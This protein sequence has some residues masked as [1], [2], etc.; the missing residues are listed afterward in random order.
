MRE[1][2]AETAHGAASA[3]VAP[4][5]GLVVAAPHSGAGKTTSTMVLIAA[6]RAR[7]L[8]VQPFKAGPDFLDPTHLTRV[9]GRPARTLDVTLTGEE[10]VVELATRA[11]RDA[12]VGVVEG[13]MG[14]FDGV[15]GR[16]DRGSTAEIAALLGWPV[17]LVVDAS[18]AARSIAAVVR[19]FR[20][21]SSAIRV[22]AVLFA[23]VAGA[24]HLQML[25]DAC[26]G[27]DVAG[28]GG[29]LADPALRIAERHL[30]LHP[31]S[32]LDGPDEAAI[33]RAAA[34]L[35]V[36]ALLDV[37]GTRGGSSHVVRARGESG[38]VLRAD[39]AHARRAAGTG[40]SVESVAGASAATTG[41]SSAPAPRC[42]IGVARDAAFCFYYED[43]L[44]ALRAA[45]A[46][47]VEWSPLRDTGL[48]DGT[49]G[50]YIGGGYP[51]LHARSL[52]VNEGVR[53][54][55][56]DF[57]ARG[58]MVYAECGGF[59]FL[60]RALA[61]VDGDRQPM[62]GL[63]PGVAAMQPRLVALGYRTW[64]WTLDGT[65]LMVRGQEFRHSALVEWPAAPVVDGEPVRVLDDAVADGGA[66][67]ASGVAWRR[68]VAGYTHLHFGATPLLAA[69]LVE[70]AVAA[71]RDLGHGVG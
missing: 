45:G 61:G 30:G 6:L 43:N 20:T 16:S 49:D 9:A 51:E 25:R 2:G 3:A 47:L 35:D 32:A 37:L 14:L 44:D 34:A 55:V 69:L 33:A 50:L 46:E 67:G 28:L 65:S 63:L 11:L 24:G 15:D 19:G 71:R 48:P 22:A 70:R 54:A 36:D 31:A 12:D 17:V 56:R 39:P 27:E 7:G 26:A 62:V 40:G 4:R 64:T 53:H 10:Y 38:D 18:A 29:V 68:V 58:G 13:M 42:R 8:R 41:A 5:P 57:A 23:R 60:Q 66:S 1:P 59:M 21:F 52:A